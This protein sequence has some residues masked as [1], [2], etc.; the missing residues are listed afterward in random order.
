MRKYRGSWAGNAAR[1]GHASEGGCMVSGN[2]H[3]HTAATH[4][5]RHD[6]PAWDQLA[7]TQRSVRLRPITRQRHAL[8]PDAKR[9]EQE[10]RVPHTLPP[11]D[12]DPE[13]QRSSCMLVR[14][15]AR[16]GA[17]R[18]RS[19]VRRRGKRAQ[20]T[21]QRSMPRRHSTATRMRTARREWPMCVSA[22]RLWQRAGRAVPCAQF[23][24]SPRCESNV[25]T[26]CE[27]AGAASR[28]TTPPAPP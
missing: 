16:T 23:F 21:R 28:P 25:A 13:Q 3:G 7:Y 18:T 20:S 6:V 10:C 26:R 4:V 8:G 27:R 22:W 11:A 24:V 12:A 19:R 5:R 14:R 9:R 15:V 2:G 1:N 17:E